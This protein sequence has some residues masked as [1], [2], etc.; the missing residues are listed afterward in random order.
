MR[1][2]AQSPPFGSICIGGVSLWRGFSLSTRERCAMNV[3]EVLDQAA[4]PEA[5]PDVDRAWATVVYR[6]QRRRTRRRV[7]AGSCAL[8]VI[9]FAGGAIALQQDSG[10]VTVAAETEDPR[11][12][13]GDAMREVEY[14]GTRF[15]VPSS[16]PLSRPDEYEFHCLTYQA[17]GVFLAPEDVSI[18]G[19]SCPATL[20]GYGSTIHVQ[21]LLVDGP[22]DRTVEGEGP[23][24]RWVIS[25]ETNRW[26][27][28]A[29]PHYGLLFTFYEL[30]EA[31]REAV[32]SS[33][34]LAGD[35]ETGATP[36]TTPASPTT[37]SPGSAEA[38]VCATRMV[39][40]AAGD[41][42]TLSRGVG[43]GRPS[44]YEV[45]FDGEPLFGGCGSDQGAKAAGHMAWFSGIVGDEALLFGEVPAGVSAVA[46]N[47]DVV[48]AVTPAGTDTGLV[49][50]TLSSVDTDLSNVTLEAVRPD[51]TRTPLAPAAISSHRNSGF[52]LVFPPE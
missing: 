44:L 16:L 34:R 19:A 39:E 29:L 14:L 21:P 38:G 26:Y 17:D 9:A 24:E 3:D 50:A 43:D 22:G 52:V 32:L 4:L 48:P 12:V 31:V 20:D 18:F 33:V 1:W 5:E 35:E 23:D 28:A 36:T 46:V 7:L 8:A 10:D 42:W 27:E 49:V 51:G 47:G 41:R 15:D 13:S 6:A 37:A 40:V 30:D 25:T 11:P 45:S 2:G